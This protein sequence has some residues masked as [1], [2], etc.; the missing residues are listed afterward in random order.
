VQTGVR[1]WE[2]QKFNVDEPYPVCAAFMLPVNLQNDAVLQSLLMFS[3]GT[4][5]G[6]TCTDGHI[7]GI[8][9]NS[10]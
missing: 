8:E 5:N 7:P 10:L 2:S 4:G 3:G 9:T 6:R 1:G